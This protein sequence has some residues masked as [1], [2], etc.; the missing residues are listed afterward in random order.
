MRC[1]FIHTKLTI[2]LNAKLSAKGGNE[3]ERHRSESD[4]I[5]NIEVEEKR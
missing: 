4:G 2:K 1:E 5:I 3:N